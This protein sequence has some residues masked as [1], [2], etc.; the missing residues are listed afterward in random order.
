MN[1][2]DE[3]LKRIKDEIDK[4]PYNLGYSGKTDAEIKEILNIPFSVLVVSS[5]ETLFPCPMNRIL[6]G[7]ES[8]P[9]AIS[10]AK[11]VTDAKASVADI[12]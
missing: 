7:I 11:L 3:I 5:A 8:A 6:Q 1:I 9:N 4:D 2:Q 10:D 12:I